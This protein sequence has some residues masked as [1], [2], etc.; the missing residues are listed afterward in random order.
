MDQALAFPRL[1]PLRR[2]QGLPPRPR[3]L[4]RRL[5]SDGLGGSRFRG[6]RGFGVP[7][8]RVPALRPQALRPQVPRRQLPRPL[9]HPAPRLPLVRAVSTDA[10]SA[11]PS[12]GARR[13]SSSCLAGRRA[14]NRPRRARSRCEMARM[15]SSL[16]GT[17][18]IRS[19]PSGSELLNRP[20]PPPECRACCASATAIDAPCWCRSPPGRLGRP[21]ISLIPPRARSCLSRSR[22]RFSRVSFLVRPT[23]SSARLSSISR[24]LLDRVGNRA[25]SW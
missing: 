13:L 22:V 14:P 21:P 20:R 23:F 12:V 18:Y 11:S 19:M 5:F 3:R 8:L 9:A 24:K 17:G 15:V 10:S 7:A 16:P 2:R 25:S 1:C 4:G 6:R